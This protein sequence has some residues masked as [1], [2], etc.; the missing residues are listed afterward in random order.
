MIKLPNKP[1]PLSDDLVNLELGRSDFWT[2]HILKS[3]PE[4]LGH[5]QGASIYGCRNQTI[6]IIKYY[7]CVLKIKFFLV[8]EDA[9]GP[10][11]L[12]M[13]E[14]RVQNLFELNY[15]IKNNVFFI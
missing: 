3:H 5:P 1:S 4:S 6:L 8:V 2:S 9:N 14:E 13:K 7:Y 15:K 12:D 11:E 10:V